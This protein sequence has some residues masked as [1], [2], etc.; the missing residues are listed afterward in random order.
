LSGRDFGVYL[1]LKLVGLT[2]AVQYR[3]RGRGRGRGRKRR[4]GERRRKRAK[5][6][7][8]SWRLVAAFLLSRCLESGDRAWLKQK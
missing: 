3:V 7:N 4:K 8:F 1:I 2:I 5:L 6:W